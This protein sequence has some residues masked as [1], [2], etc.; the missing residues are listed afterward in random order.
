MTGKSTVSELV[1]H[2]VDVSASWFV[3]EMSAKRLITPTLGSCVASYFVSFNTQSKPRFDFHT[4]LC[5]SL[6]SDVVLKAK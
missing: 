5:E 2:R 3:S 1:C 4:D 6:I